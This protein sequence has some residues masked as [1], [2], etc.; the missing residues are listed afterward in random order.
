MNHVLR[1]D[2][3]TNKGGEKTTYVIYV[4][5][6]KYLVYFSDTSLRFCCPQNC[7]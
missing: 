7:G 3:D 5:F 6:P 2:V 1:T 4:Q